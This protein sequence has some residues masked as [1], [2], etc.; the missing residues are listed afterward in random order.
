MLEAAQQDEPV[1]DFVGFVE[2]FG[3]SG[4]VGV[5]EL[6]VGAAFGCFFGWSEVHYLAEVGVGC[7]G[8]FGWAVVAVDDGLREG[9]FVCL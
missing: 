5:Y 6:L 2:H 7:G 8:I 9:F 4:E 1:V 3:V